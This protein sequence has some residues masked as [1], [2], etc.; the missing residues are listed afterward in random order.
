MPKAKDLPADAFVTSVV[1][2]LVSSGQSFTFQHAK[3]LLKRSI[4]K[5]PEGKAKA[6]GEA[7]LPVLKRLLKKKLQD[8]VPAAEPR[9]N[10]ISSVG[11]AQAFVSVVRTGD[12]VSG[13]LQARLPAHPALLERVL[14][15][16]ESA[17]FEKSIN[18]LMASSEWPDIGHV[19]IHA[20]RHF[21]SEL[22][23]M[24]E[25]CITT[26][27][28]EVRRKGPLATSANM[29]HVTPV[30]AADAGT[31]RLAEIRK[32]INSIAALCPLHRS[33]SNPV[34]FILSNACQPAH[35]PIATL[36]FTA[37]IAHALERLQAL[38]GP[39]LTSGELRQT[40][41][42]VQQHVHRLAAGLQANPAE[43]DCFLLQHPVTEIESCSSD[44]WAA[45]PCIGW[46]AIFNL[47]SL[48][49]LRAM[50]TLTATAILL[51]RR[52]SQRHACL[53]DKAASE[54]AA[55]ALSGKACSAA[56]CSLVAGLQQP[57][58]LVA[59]C[60]RQDACHPAKLGDFLMRYPDEEDLSQLQ[61]HVLSS[62][63][64]VPKAVVEGD[65]D[66]DALFV[67]DAHADPAFTGAWSAPGEE[68]GASDQVCG[69]LHLCDSSC[70]LNH[71]WTCLM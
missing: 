46:L 70:L 27:R 4:A 36:L 33:P 55:V 29:L 20:C 19:I 1:D 57:A 41:T 5:L 25:S 60:Q 14:S 53:G 21:S 39:W 49:R 13:L 12:K 8:I 68:S 10:V 3:K 35:C 38:D 48:P 42:H 50:P 61:R 44:S 69:L 6:A 31:G 47:V 9:G 51:Q 62:S 45:V 24:A 64:S 63:D 71:Q 66:D 2:L 7:Q 23:Q 37:A 40:I 54:K 30:L 11:S 58:R 67:L 56:T 43:V 32:A 16:Q 52:C 34:N 15:Q 18:H 17:V 22:R 59:A 26:Q 28:H 65:N